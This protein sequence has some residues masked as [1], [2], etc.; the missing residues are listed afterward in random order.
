[1]SDPKITYGTVEVTDE[2]LAPEAARIRLSCMIPLVLS[3][4]LRRYAKVSGVTLEELVGRALEEYL[5]L[6]GEE[7]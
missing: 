1:M 2:Q 3:R 4:T 5:D 6:R 7:P